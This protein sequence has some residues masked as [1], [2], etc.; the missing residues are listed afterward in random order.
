MNN[1]PLNGSSFIG[2]AEKY[3]EAISSGGVP[4][5]SSAWQEVMQ[6][7]CESGLNEALE[8]YDSEIERIL[9]EVGGGVC[10]P[11]LLHK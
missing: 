2:L 11:A 6:K 3:I 10:L 5:V 1:V 9:A 4:T 8:H 7:E